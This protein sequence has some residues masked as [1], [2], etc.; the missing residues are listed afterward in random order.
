[1]DS[2]THIDEH[3]DTAQ[4]FTAE[5]LP[6]QRRLSIPT[7]VNSGVVGHVVERID[8]SGESHVQVGNNIRNLVHVG[9]SS[10]APMMRRG[11]DMV[12]RCP[13]Q[14]KPELCRHNGS[15]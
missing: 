13:L 2:A 10:L 4:D 11:T 7:Y 12:L 8:A 3:F 9:K 6:P 15:P 5:P 14:G 1:M